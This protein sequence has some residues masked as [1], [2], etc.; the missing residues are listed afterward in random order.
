M[1]DD[2]QAVG[3]LVFRQQVAQRSPV[4]GTLDRKRLG[5]CLRAEIWIRC[6]HHSEIID[7]ISAVQLTNPYGS[8]RIDFA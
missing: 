2:P 5:H 4:A 8:M 3:V 7:S 6:S 1:D